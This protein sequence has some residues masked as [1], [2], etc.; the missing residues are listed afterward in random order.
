[1]WS[2]VAIARYLKGHKYMKLIF[3][4]HSRDLCVLLAAKSPGYDC[5]IENIKFRVNYVVYLELS[6]IVNTHAHAHIHTHTHTHTPI[7]RQLL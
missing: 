3:N 6:Y 4:L 1:M 7:Y 5:N 2:E